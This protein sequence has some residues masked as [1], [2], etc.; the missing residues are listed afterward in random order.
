VL[1]DLLNL[2]RKAASQ[3]SP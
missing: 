2:E 3:L 1:E